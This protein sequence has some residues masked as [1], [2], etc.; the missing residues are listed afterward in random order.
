MLRLLD[1]EIPDAPPDDDVT[2]Q[3]VSVEDADALYADRF[4]MSTLALEAGHQIGYHPVDDAVAFRARPNGVAPPC[5]GADVL[6]GGCSRMT[7]TRWAARGERGPVS[8]PQSLPRESRSVTSWNGRSCRLH[9][10][11][12]T[13]RSRARDDGRARSSRSVSV[14]AASND[15]TTRAADRLPFAS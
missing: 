3:R 9:S 4:G 11:S 5:P 7:Q 14:A 1:L 8:T 6:L 13:D 2:W 10:R 12:P 15:A